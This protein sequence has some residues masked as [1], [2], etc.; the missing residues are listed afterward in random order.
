MKDLVTKACECEKM[1]GVKNDK[2][3]VQNIKLLLLIS[4]SCEE[5]LGDF[6]SQ[7]TFSKNQRTLVITVE[8]L[9]WSL[10]SVG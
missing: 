2:R 4:I 10:N 5:N 7:S 3:S 9:S 8:L 6:S 1:E